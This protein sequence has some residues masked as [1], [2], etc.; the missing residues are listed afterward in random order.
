VLILGGST[1]A[2]QLARK[3]AP[4]DAYDVTVSYAGRT[5]ERT[6]TPGRIRVGGFGGIDGLAEHL[7]SH[8][9][10]VVIDATHP[11]AK[12]M[13]HHAAAACETV[14]VAR[15]RVC[16][17]PWEAVAGDRWHEVSNLDTASEVLADLGL[18]RVFLTTGRQ[19]LQ[20]FAGLAD[21][22]FLV[23]AIEPPAHMPLAHAS[24][25]LARGPFDEAGELALLRD[26]GIEL[27]VT[28]NSGGTAAA[29][30]LT[31]A[32]EL[33]LPVVMVTRPPGP[34]GPCAS[35]VDEAMAWIAPLEDAPIGAA[36]PGAAG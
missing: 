24:V 20:P 33:G 36:Q 9:V 25:I 7:V 5:R 26:H 32:R 30:K 14:G 35:S 15:L 23:R 21:T 27:V 2:S 3:L 22:W 10:D 28:K 19:E 34:P 17:P 11:F 8:R 16:R 1:E 29:A 13:P 4:H 6:S 12:R 31:A 18:R